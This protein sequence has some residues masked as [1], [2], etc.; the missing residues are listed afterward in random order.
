MIT[1]KHV[2]Y[3]SARIDESRIKSKELRDDLLDHFCCVIEEEMGKGIDFDAA[4]ATAF[5]QITPNGFDALY[6]ETMFLLNRR[7]IILLKQAIYFSGYLFTLISVTGVFFKKMYWPGATMLLIVGLSGLLCVFIPLKL[8]DRYKVKANKLLSE[9]LKRTL[10][11]S[12]LVILGMVATMMATH[13]T[14]ASYV[15]LF[16]VFVLGFGLLP[17]LFFR[18][19]KKSTEQ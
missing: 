12:V 8:L 2:D 18:M 5:D 19:Y 16:A 10:G 3:V 14:G 15:L 4:Y 9:R 1:E 7:K 17:F 6:K 11:S 13:T